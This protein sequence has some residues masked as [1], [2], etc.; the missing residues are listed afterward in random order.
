MHHHPNESDLALYAGN[1]LGRI[2]RLRVDW[3]LRSCGKCQQEVTDFSSLRAETVRT[4]SEPEVNWDRL[5]AEMKANIHLGLEAGECIAPVQSRHR[6]QSPW[7]WA[8]LATAA[9]IAIA[10]GSEVWINHPW[11][12][13]NPAD[14]PVLAGMPPLEDVML[15][16]TDSGIR[17]RDGETV[18]SELRNNSRA[19]IVNSVIVN[20]VNAEGGVGASYVDSKTGMVTVNN[21]YYGQ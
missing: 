5:A 19:D 21:I 6:P 16:V 9:L 13:A 3:H 10:A 4:A 11:S 1:D 17:M 7:A 8:T 15:E 14:A 20:S 12:P 18:V 2:A